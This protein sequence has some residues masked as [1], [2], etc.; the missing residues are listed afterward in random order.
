MEIGLKRLMRKSTKRANKRPL[1]SGL[2]GNSMA[3]R[4]FEFNKTYEEVEVAGEVFRIEFNDEKIQQYNRGFDKYYVESKK[5]KEKD[6]KKMNSEDKEKMFKQMQDLTKDMVEE[7]LGEG[8]YESLYKASGNSLMN[9]IE[10][11]EYLSEIIGEVSERI[12]ESKKKK[13]LANKKR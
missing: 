4:K 8:T 1:N 9:M 3:I 7:I 6:L 11:V 2:G 13:Y 12:R 5:I 10:L